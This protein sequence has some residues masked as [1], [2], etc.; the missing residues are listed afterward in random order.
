MM[1]LIG[2]VSN[3]RLFCTVKPTTFEDD[4]EL[5]ECLGQGSTARVYRSLDVR[6]N[7]Q[8]IVKLFKKVVEH[9]IERESRMLWA[10]KSCPHVQQLKEIVQNVGFMNYGFVFEYY[11]GDT[12]NKFIK[13]LTLPQIKLY[14]LQLLMALRCLHSKGIMHR[15][16]KPSN[17]LI[18]KE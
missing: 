5:I 8:V 13:N 16:I 7:Q 10:V 3:R 18:S 4:Y 6:T 2:R 9:K 14:T 12:L 1:N 15:D 11:P 17:I